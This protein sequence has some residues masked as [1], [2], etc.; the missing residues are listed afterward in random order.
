MPATK[1]TEGGAIDTGEFR[2]VTVLFAN[3]YPFSVTLDLLGDDCDTAVSVLNAYYRRAQEVVHRYGGIVNKVDMYTFGDKLM[4]L[5]GAPAANE[6]DPLRAARAALDLRGALAQANH[7]IFD[8]LNPQ[9]GRLIQVDPQFLKQRVGLNTG[10]VF[11]GQV[12]SARRHEY[13]VMG[14][15]VNL[16]AR[17]MSAAEEGAVIVSPAT[18]RVIERHIAMQELAPVKLKGIEEPVPIAQALHP[19]EI[20]QDA[21]RSVAR[22]QL[23]GREQEMQ[24]MIAEARAALG[25]SGRIIALA[26]EAGAGKTRLIE[27]ALQRLVMLSADS[28]SGI[29]TVLPLQ[30]RVPELRAKHCLCGGARAAAP[31]FQLAPGRRFGR[32]SWRLSSAAWPSWRRIWRAS[33]HCWATCWGSRSMIRR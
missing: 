12:G 25:S 33:H 26:G 16:S 15:H 24:R 13:T 7:E 32:S 28:E 22:P 27:D 8:L 21:R 2:P 23:V 18:R 29:A 17:L 9:I 3:F 19:Y 11:A 10:V 30:R 1:S 31:V 6:D 14:Q 5:F 20:A 4:A